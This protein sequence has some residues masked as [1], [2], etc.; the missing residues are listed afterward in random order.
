MTCTE[1]DDLLAAC[2]VEQI[3]TAT[4]R[5]TR[6]AEVN[7]NATQ[8]SSRVV[9]QTTKATQRSTRI[10]KQTKK[11]TQPSTQNTK[12]QSAESRR[13]Q[14]NRIIEFFR[15]WCDTKG[16]TDAH[17]QTLVDTSRDRRSAATTRLPP[18]PTPGPHA[19]IPRK[20]LGEIMRGLLQPVAVTLLYR[21]DRMARQ[22][23]AAAPGGA[24]LAAPRT[25]MRRIQMR[26]L[27]KASPLRQVVSLA[28]GRGGKSKDSTALAMNNDDSNECC[29][30]IGLVGSLWRITTPPPFR[31]GRSCCSEE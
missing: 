10:A 7:K 26:A 27:A 11:A 12:L 29:R 31:L 18:S 13:S 1:C 4:R 8:S 2:T 19:G 5:S 30:S 6:I 24:K 15:L 20:P 3:Q 28:R 17:F 21:P 25:A 16:L 22:R 23:S 9:R 14:N